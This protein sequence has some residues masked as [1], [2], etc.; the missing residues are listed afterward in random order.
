MKLRS[1]N[2]IIHGAKEEPEHGKK[3]TKGSSVHSWKPWGLVTSKPEAIVRL[4]IKSP[5][6]IRPLKLKMTS[7]EEQ[8]V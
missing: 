4:G 1:L 2:I 6:K 3:M 7:V 8:I 5:E